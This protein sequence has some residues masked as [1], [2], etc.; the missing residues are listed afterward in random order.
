MHVLN[1]DIHDTYYVYLNVNHN[2]AKHQNS[3]QSNDLCSL[4]NLH[5]TISPALFHTRLGARK[6]NQN[7]DLP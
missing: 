4:T 5:S 1:P 2:E 3:S 6:K 7:R